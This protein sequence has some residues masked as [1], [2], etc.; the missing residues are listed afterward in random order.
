MIA[1]VNEMFAH[2]HALVHNYIDEY[3]PTNL[4][5]VLVLTTIY[6]IV[7]HM[8][9]A[10]IRFLH[11]IIKTQYVRMFLKYQCLDV[12]KLKQEQKY[13][14]IVFMLLHD[15]FC[16]VEH[17]IDV[18]EK[19]E[20]VV[21]RHAQS[22]I[23]EHYDGWKELFATMHTVWTV[24]YKSELIACVFS[25][26]M[27][28]KNRNFPEFENNEMISFEPS[29]Y[30]LQALYVHRKFRRRR[31]ATRLISHIKQ[32]AQSSGIY[33]LELYVDEHKGPAN[34]I[35]SHIWKLSMYRKMGFISIPRPPHKDYLLMCADWDLKL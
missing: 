11:K 13:E 14:L 35:K 22:C 25:K 24:H 17:G 26:Q 32:K 7:P 16:N 28:W 8:F 27:K 20:K 31:V 5:F 33:W 15:P 10:F 21:N 30:D 1:S 6:L 4:S 34:D 29:Y 19:V 9:C 23:Q 3:I 2:F 12:R 18:D